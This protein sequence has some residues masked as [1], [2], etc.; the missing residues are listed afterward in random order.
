VV[1]A[2]VS[3]SAPANRLPPPPPSPA[4]RW[5][6]ALISGAGLTA[7]AIA[8]AHTNP[9]QAE[10]ESYAADRLVELIVPEVCGTGGMPTPL[11]LIL[12]NCPDLIASQ[13]GVLGTLAWRGTRRQNLG[14]FSLYRTTLG[15]HEVLPILNLPLYRAITLGIGGRF[16]ILETSGGR[17]PQN[18]EPEGR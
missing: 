3:S 7:G 2:N 17:E 18:L 12:E 4:G 10:F 5:W 16:F 14:L 11:R 9:G 15:G 1:F 13:R 8:L 6:L